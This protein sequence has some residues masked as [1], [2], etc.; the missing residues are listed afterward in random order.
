M[1]EISSFEGFSK[2][3]ISF[4]NDTVNNNSKEWLNDNRNRY[5]KVLVHP[6]KQ[7]FNELA[8]TIS[9]IDPQIDIEPRVGR[10]ISKIFR[11]VRFSSNKS[12]LRANMWLVFKPRGSVSLFTPSFYFDISYDKWSYGMGFYS[13]TPGYMRM[14]RDKLLAE[15]EPFLKSVAV[16]DSKLELNAENYKRPPVKHYPETLNSKQIQELSPWLMKKSFYWS[17]SKEHNKELFSADLIT[18]LSSDFITLGDVY[19]Y[20]VKLE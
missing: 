16:V 10:T 11:D 3:T 14:F 20:L 19:N 8:P 5:E 4:L 6:M 15:P 7:L 17:C 13:A 18:I 12:P 2:D 9:S 1:A